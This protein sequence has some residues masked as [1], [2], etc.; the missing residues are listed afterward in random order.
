[1]MFAYFLRKKGSENKE[2]FFLL[3]VVK[4]KHILIVLVFVNL[5]FQ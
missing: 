2:A 3:E 4:E 1:M 5:C